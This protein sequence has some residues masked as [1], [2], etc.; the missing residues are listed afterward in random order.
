MLRE[1]SPS[2]RHAGQSDAPSHLKSKQLGPLRRLSPY[3]APHGIRIAFSILALVVA[4]ATV[5][6]IGRGL[7]FFVDTGIRQ[8]NDQTMDIALAVMLAGITVLA[9]AS[10]GRVYL[11]TW[12]GERVINDLRHD[13]FAHIIRLD[14]G[15]LDDRKTGD[16]ISRMTNDTGLLQVIITTTVPIALRN[17]VLTIGGLIFL[18]IISPK[19]TGLV[20]VA[21]PLI[22]IPIAILGPKLRQKSTLRQNAIGELGNLTSEGLYGLR[23]VQAFGRQDGLSDKF[24]QQAGRVFDAGINYI[25]DRA[26]LSSTIIFIVFSAVGVVLW[27]GGQDVMAGQMTAG[28]LSS[29]VFYALVV[30]ASS[31]TLSEIY[32]EV[33]LAAGACD[34]IFDIMDTPSAITWP[35]DPVRLP[36]PVEGEIIFDQVEFAYPSRP[37]QLVLQQ[38]SARINPGQTVALVGPSGAGK[39][40]VL[41]LL[42]RFYRVNGQIK[43]DGIDIEKLDP[44]DLRSCIGMV[45][46]E[47]TIFSGTAYDNIAFGA[48]DANRDQV[49]VAAKAANA[50]DFITHFPDGYDTELGERGMRLSGGQAQ[51]IAIARAILRN[52]AVLLL[53]EAT[54]ALDAENEQQI[55]SALHRIS[56]G[57]TTLIIAHRLSTVRDADHILVM[58]NGRLVDQGT[59]DELMAKQNGLYARLAMLQL[60]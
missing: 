56:A 27:I 6:G 22:V 48:T 18:L 16:L 25:R 9:I 4:A 5:L 19:L 37:D 21:I 60:E 23:I 26:L 20:A 45:A 53:D 55:Q 58:D 28:Q 43:L 15:F 38:F 36:S 33:Q 51:R 46:Q 59:H 10:Y 54:S 34:R 57:R 24:G 35:Q 30:A 29:F 14:P 41:N 52:P 1:P 3:L 42:L 31:G 2:E 32:G 13:L 40:T 17:I 49:I 47:A 12:L 7:Q 11:L 8:Q 44:D 50:H 39:S